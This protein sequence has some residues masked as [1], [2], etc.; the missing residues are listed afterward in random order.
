MLQSFRDISKTHTNI[1]LSLPAKRSS[2]ALEI[3][4]YLSKQKERA[5]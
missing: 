1:A 2:L 3:S 4:L 5:C